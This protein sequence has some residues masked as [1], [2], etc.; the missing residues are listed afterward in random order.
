MIIIL[1]TPFQVFSA[2]K[3]V[4]VELHYEMLIPHKLSG[5]KIEGA[6]PGLR[7]KPRD[8]YQWKFNDWTECSVTCGNGRL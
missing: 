5:I 4:P 2:T 1:P 6:E 3:R 8:I 7:T